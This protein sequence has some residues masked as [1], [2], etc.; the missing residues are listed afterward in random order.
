[1]IYLRKIP[2]DIIINHIIPYTYQTQTKNLLLDIISFKKDFDI[3][4]NI[5]TFDY[6]FNILLQ[7]LLLFY[8]D[9]LDLFLSISNLTNKKLWGL[10]SI[11][12]RTHFINKHIE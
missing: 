11:S 8:E 4:K 7:D 1:M 10:L 12:Q 6:N 2:N 9:E 5:Y 3:I